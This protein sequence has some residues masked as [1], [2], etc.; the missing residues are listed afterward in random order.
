MK[1]LLKYHPP[2]QV[3]A[4]KTGV[5]SLCWK[6]MCHLGVT[7]GWK[8]F[9]PIFVKTCTLDFIFSF[10]ETVHSDLH[11]SR[12]SRSPGFKEIKDWLTFVISTN[13]SR[14]LTVL[15]FLLYD[16]Y[17]FFFFFKSSGYQV[18]RFLKFC[19]IFS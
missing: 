12:G 1:I 19:P 17:F 8:I 5:L 16:C 15:V 11:L 10:V 14:D 3:V 9:S 13:V 4:S 7:D 6:C 2:V 18:H